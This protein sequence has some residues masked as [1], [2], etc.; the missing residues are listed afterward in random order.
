[1]AGRKVSAIINILS[2]PKHEKRAN[3]RII[4]IRL[5]RSEPRPMI[6]VKIARNVGNAIWLNVEK[7]T[8]A[9]ESAFFEQAMYSE[10]MWRQYAVPTA[11]RKIGTI[12]VNMERGI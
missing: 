3:S 10:T 7:V 4:V 11:M 9:G 2:M 1:M 12:I 6:V 8:S 5:T